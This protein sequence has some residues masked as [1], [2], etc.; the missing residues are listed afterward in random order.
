MSAVSVLVCFPVREEARF[1][2]VPAARA[3]IT[4]IGRANTERTL[5][6]ALAS[7]PPPLVLSCGFGGGLNPDLPAGTVIFDA[8]EVPGMPDRLL[9]AGARP[10]RFHSVDRVITTVGEKQKLRASTNADVVEMESHYVRSLCRSRGIPSATLRVISDPADQDLPLDFNQLM[11]P[12]LQLSYLRL[13]R[14]LAM[15]PGKIP[16]LLRL[17][18]QTELAARNLARV[19]AEVLADRPASAP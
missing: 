10:A 2:S 3:L 5:T 9:A 14:A 13:M 6:T 8:A 7:A 11:T 1:F 15:A 16:A 4:G 12:D 19:L 17:Q 18:K